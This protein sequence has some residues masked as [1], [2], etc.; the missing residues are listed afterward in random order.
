MKMIAKNPQDRFA[1]ADQCRE[2]WTEIGAK[3]GIIAVTRSGEFR[4]QPD[5][6]APVPPA[7]KPMSGGKPT[8]GIN[9]APAQQ[10]SMP[11][12][13]LAPQTERRIGAEKSTAGG[14]GASGENLAKGT[15]ERQ[16]QSSTT[17]RR[18]S[19]RTSATEAITC[20]R[21]GMLN[22]SELKACQ[23]CGTALHKSANLTIKDQEAHA[24][25]LASKGGYREAAETYSR[26]ADQETDRKQ[27]SIWRS[28]E[29]EARNFEQEKHLAELSNRSTAHLDRGDLQSSLEVLEKGLHEVRGVGSSTDTIETH[30]MQ[31]IT[32]LRQRIGWRRRRKTIL[33]LILLAVALVVAWFGWQKMQG[34]AGAIS[35]LLRQSSDHHPAAMIDAY[36]REDGAT[37]APGAI[38][39]RNESI[40]GIAHVKSRSDVRYAG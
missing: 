25:E 31:Q 17:E 36:N 15:T 35:Y 13:E 24:A 40:A 29:R 34:K 22:R 27:R 37:G 39:P 11:A 33:F 26:M 20:A 7:E 19:G 4:F 14:P 8:G 3:L 5:A 1:D 30:L 16:R 28:K 2:H 12:P 32:D 6:S 18:Q 23:R 21:C 9:L 10:S 38:S